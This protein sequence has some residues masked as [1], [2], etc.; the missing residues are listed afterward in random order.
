MLAIPRIEAENER[1]LMALRHQRAL[2][3]VVESDRITQAFASRTFTRER[4]C[5]E[6]VAY[7]T[8]AYAADQ[9]TRLGARF[10]HSL[11]LYFCQW[12]HRYHL[13]TEKV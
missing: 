6:K 9:A 10:G 7:R 12:C 1:L 5:A 13:T 3:R 11:R 2:G 4:G 8:P